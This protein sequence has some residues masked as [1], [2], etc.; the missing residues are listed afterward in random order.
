MA[1][2][3]L[4]GPRLESI[5]KCP[6]RN[7]RDTC[8]CIYVLHI[9][10]LHN[11]HRSRCLNLYNTVPILNTVPFNYLR[12]LYIVGTICELFGFNNRR[13]LL[14]VIFKH[15]RRGF[16]WFSY[17]FRTLTYSFAPLFC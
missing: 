2:L 14:D 9:V 4:H 3:A 6:L 10:V 11:I 1:A 15:V 17:Q 7:K 16:D 5:L 12:N 13:L 8:T